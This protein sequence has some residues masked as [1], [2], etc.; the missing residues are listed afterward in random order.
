VTEC[1]PPNDEAARIWRAVPVRRWR[2]TLASLPEYASLNGVR[3]EYREAV[4]ERLRVAHR[5]LH[6][7]ITYINM[8]K[9]EFQCEVGQED[10]H[11]AN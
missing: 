10:Q 11:A 8:S 6:S 3:W 9:A 1:A 2:E 7:G 5:N 4:K